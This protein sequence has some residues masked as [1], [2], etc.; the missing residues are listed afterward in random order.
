MQQRMNTDHLT[1]YPVHLART[2]ERLLVPAQ[3]WREALKVTGRPDACLIEERVDLLGDSGA[4]IDVTF[5]PDTPT[6]ITTRCRQGTDV[7]RVSFALSCVADYLD[8][9]L[10]GAVRA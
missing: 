4:T 9:E 6:T 1:T 7:E 5:D 8:K 3:D 10:A 2:G